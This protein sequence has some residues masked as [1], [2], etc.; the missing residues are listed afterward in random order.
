M[1]LHQPELRELSERAR[2]LLSAMGRP[3]NRSTGVSVAADGG[4]VVVA[5]G[6]D[7]TLNVHLPENGKW[8]RS[9]YCEHGRGQS[10][11]MDHVACRV[12][13]RRLQALQVLDDLSEV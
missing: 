9:I 8:G 3:W 2:R 13:L 11:Y 5:L 12:A 4:D 7:G 6:T 1:T 10:L